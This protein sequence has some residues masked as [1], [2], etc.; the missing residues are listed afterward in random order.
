M[1]TIYESIAEIMKKGYVISKDSKNSTQNFMYRG[2][3]DVM[4]TF[5]PLMAEVGIFV[6]PEVLEETRE[7][8]VSKTGSALIYSI[9]KVK[10]TFYA[11][12]GT[13]V[14]AVVIG[15]GMDSGDKSS[16]KAMAIAMKYAMF[17]VFCIPTEEI[18]DPDSESHEVKPKAKAKAEP[19]EEPKAVPKAEPKVEKPIEY[20]CSKCHKKIT[21]EIGGK[22]LKGKLYC[23]PCLAKM[24]DENKN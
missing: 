17:Q 4:N 12:D 9:L 22:Q 15:E 3:D 24:N 1:A 23:N 6:V 14:S 16:N 7:E 5:Q 20:V 18:I 11:S 19:K 13:N 8:R 10:Y 21:K 2:I